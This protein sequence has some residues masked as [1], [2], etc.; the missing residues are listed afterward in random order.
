E[1]G[2]APSGWAFG[3]PSP[4]FS[5]ARTAGIRIVLLDRGYRHDIAQTSPWLLA[6]AKTLSYAVNR[7]AFREAARRGADDSLFVSSDGYLLEGPVSTLIIRRG[8]H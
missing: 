8:R 1:G 3:A 6:G 7:A 5:A 2:D 4:D